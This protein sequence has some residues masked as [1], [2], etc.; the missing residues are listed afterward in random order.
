MM[1]VIY[2][3]INGGDIVLFKQLGIIAFDVKYHYGLSLII[4]YEPEE[5]F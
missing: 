4:F 2:P 3:E 1:V 5:S